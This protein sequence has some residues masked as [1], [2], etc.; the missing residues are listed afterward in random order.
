MALLR[1]DPF[2][3]VDRLFQQLAAQ[4]APRS[5]MSMP[6]DAYRKGDQFL[7]QM[8]LPGVDPEH[9]DITVEDNVLTVK[10]ER[11]AP[12][13]SEDV[14]SLVTER[15]YGTFSRQLFL[16]RNLDTDRIEAQYDAGVLSLSIPV[17]EHAKA[18]RIPVDARSE[19]AR[20]AV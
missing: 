16:G 17:A 2:R 9:V 18:R 3:D 4:P 14:E 6:I 19:P 11:P 20:L 10:A 5:S 1:S 8:E 7:I 13:T 12:S 15:S